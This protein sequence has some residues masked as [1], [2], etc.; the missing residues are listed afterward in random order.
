[1]ANG[2]TPSFQFPWG[3]DHGAKDDPGSEWQNLVPGELSHALLRMALSQPL[4][5]VCEGKTQPDPQVPTS[6]VPGTL[7][8]S[9]YSQVYTVSSYFTFL[10]VSVKG[11]HTSV[12]LIT[13]KLNIVTVFMHRRRRKLDL[14]TH[15]SIRTICPQ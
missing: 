5:Q 8:M 10:P 1:M 2:M 3:Q 13:I 12:K 7:T 4:P 15:C 6:Y 11:T 14:D 9:P